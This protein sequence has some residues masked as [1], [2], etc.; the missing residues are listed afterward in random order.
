VVICGSLV[1][2]GCKNAIESGFNPSLSGDDLVRM[3]DDMAMKI[4]G[5]ADVQREYQLHGPLKIVV[6]PV[7]NE[8]TAEV[9]PRGAAEAFTARVRTLLSQH[10]PDRFTWIMNRDTYYHLRERELD[11]DLGTAPGAINP[12]YALTATFSSLTKEN[13]KRRSSYYLCVYELT[14]IDHRT[15]LWT[16]KYE[17]K[18]EAV[19]GFLD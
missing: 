11:T 13:S 3:T 10:D 18:K 8:M 19:K 7:R 17:L 5:D 4:A 15:V 2:S 14:D 6:E 9:L 1:L 16:D 12:Q